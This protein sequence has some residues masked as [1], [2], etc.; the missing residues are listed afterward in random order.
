MRVIHH[1]VR[2]EPCAQTI[3]QPMGALVLMDTQEKT[4]KLVRFAP[5]TSPCS[6][7]IYDLVL[8]VKVKW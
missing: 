7:L 6:L 4:V 8:K 1:R 2:M 3:G 5:K